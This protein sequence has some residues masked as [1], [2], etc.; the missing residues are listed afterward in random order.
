MKA[1]VTHEK[2]AGEI[3]SGFDEIADQVRSFYFVIKLHPRSTY[4]KYYIAMFYFEL[5]GFLVCIMREWYQSS[6]RRFSKSLGSSFLESTVQG[7][8]STLSLYTKRVEAEDARRTREMTTRQLYAL[9]AMVQAGLA[10]Q[11]KA[12]KDMR[13]DYAMLSTYVKQDL[14]T[15]IVQDVFKDG[16]FQVNQTTEPLPLSGNK[17]RSIEGGTSPEPDQRVAPSWSR[18]S[19]Q[20]DVAHLRLYVQAAAHVQRLIDLSHS[21]AVNTDM[22]GRVHQWVMNTSSE[23][24]WIEG[25][26]GT[27]QPSQSTL[28]SAFMLGNLRRVR[29]P[30]M[31]EFCQYDPRYWK[32]W[33]AEK[34]LLNVIYALVYQAATML[35]ETL[36]PELV[37]LD[38]SPSRFQALDGNAE[39]LPAAVKLLADLI[40]VG[41]PLQFLLVDGLQLFDGRQLTPLVQNTVAD[42][43]AVLCKAAADASVERVF[44]VLFTTDGMVTELADAAKAK[45]LSRQRCESENEDELLTFKDIDLIK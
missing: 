31:V 19:I 41:P 16:S 1:T 37:Q 10:S 6:W 15:K 4:I 28:T 25:P 13:R 5:F 44:K 43:V 18:D 23:A 30:A 17:A 20:T 21:I 3:S 24:L 22:S 35:P 32:T 45:L 34:E 27:A 33:N 42:F 38:F 2:I 26:S 11:A 8:L 12:Q 7:T 40:E 29:I 39:T 36:E 9:G 14:P